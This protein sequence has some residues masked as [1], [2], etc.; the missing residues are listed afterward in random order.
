MI[1]SYNTFNKFLETLACETE[2][3]ADMPD[4]DPFKQRQVFRPRK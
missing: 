2:V 4:H 1:V 3:C